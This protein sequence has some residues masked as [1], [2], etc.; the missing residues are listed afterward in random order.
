MKGGAYFDVM[1]YH[2]YPHIDGSLR[3]W[4]NFPPGWDYE[5]TSDNALRGVFD[6]RDRFK[7]VLDKYGY[8]GKTYPKK[9]WIITEVN[10]PRKQVKDFI[11]SDEAQRNFL[12]KLAAESKKED[13]KQLHLYN[14]AEGT[15]I[16]PTADDEF[17]FMGIYETLNDTPLYKHKKT[18]GGIA[19]E[20][21][22]LLMKNTVFDKD[23]TDRLP[24]QEGV[25][26]YAF[27][28]DKNDPIYVLWAECK[29]DQSEEAKANY[30]ILDQWRKDGME[31][32]YWDHAVSKKSEDFYRQELRL[33]GTP[34]F[35]KCP[36]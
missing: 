35:L 11:G 30:P 22:C 36:K 7:G 26:A 12:I 1:S 13:I 19:Y 34:I 29:E 10:I 25:R 21:A 24:K 28:D 31:I 14:L 5:R 20:T 17:A 23:E 9:H 6:Q 3:E 16:H 4:Q 32:H 8:D 27:R 33:S 15:R 2:A 18:Q